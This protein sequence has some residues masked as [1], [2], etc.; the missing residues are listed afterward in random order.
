MINSLQIMNP[1][2]LVLYS[3]W[4][5]DGS[6]EQCEYK[7]ILAGESELISDA[8]LLI[9]SLVPIRLINEDTNDVIWQNPSSVRFCRPISIEFSKETPEKTNNLVNDIEAQIRVLAPT[10]AIIGE[11]TV[12]IK[13]E[14]LLTMV[15]GKVV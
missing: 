11:K 8:N 9:S 6:S 1:R 10:S 13:H 3:K 7:Q 5:C 15:D 4:G 12:T 14:L 2:N